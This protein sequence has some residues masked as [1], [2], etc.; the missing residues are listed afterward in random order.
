MKLIIVDDSELMREALRG[1]IGQNSAYEVI[2][3]AGSGTEFLNLT[4]LDDADLILMDI[5]MKD[6]S[7]ITAVKNLFKTHPNK[8]VIAVTN[9]REK[10]YHHL[11]VFNGF[12]GCVFKDEVYN[13]LFQAMEIVMKEGV[14]F[15][16]EFN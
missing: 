8:K 4:C 14:F 6:M 7:G 12:K 11:L 9:Y 1:F 5:S 15:S 3:E 2:A 10:A 13:H 16:S